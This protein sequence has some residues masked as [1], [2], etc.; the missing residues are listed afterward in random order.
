MSHRSHCGLVQRI[1]GF[2]ARRS[3]FHSLIVLLSAAL[4]LVAYPLRGDV[5][6]AETLKAELVA[7]PENGYA[8]L[9]IT[10]PGRSLLP[11]YDA[12]ITNNVLKIS[13]QDPISVKVDN[14]PLKLPTYVSIARQDPDGSAIRLALT[15]EYR[16]N[17]MEAG[18]KLFID[19]LPA[20]WSG[21]TPP[22]P[23][24][25]VKEL[26]LRAEE[27]LKKARA[28]ELA[29]LRGQVEPEVSLR[30]G[31]HP[32]FTRLAFLWNLP[33]D[34]AFVREGDIVK[35]TFNYD[36]DLDLSQLRAHL[37][38][39]I[40]DA[41]SFVDEGKLKFLLRLAKGVDIRAFR[42]EST[43]V[44]DVT[45]EGQALDPINETVQ[46]IL[47]PD[48]P[49]GAREIISA[50]GTP[51]VA[52]SEPK[53]PA[54][55]GHPAPVAQDKVVTPIIK[56]SAAEDKARAP[57][58]NASRSPSAGQPA[59]EGH[60]LPPAI[61][62]GAVEPKALTPLVGRTPPSSPE[63]TPAGFDDVARRF[64]AAEARRIGN[65]VRVVF[66]FPEPV[67]SAVFRRNHSIWLIFDTADP[68]DIRGMRSVLAKD[69]EDVEVVAH[70]DWQSI[71]VDLTDNA[72][73]TVGNDGNSWVMTIGESILE[74]SRPLLLERNV[75]SDGGTILHVPLQEPQYMRQLKDPFVGDAIT[76]V[77][78]FG[79][80]RG[81]LKPQSFAELE[82]LMSAHGLAVLSRIDDLQVEL[83][84]DAVLLQGPRGLFLSNDT[85]KH[86]SRIL[87]TIVDPAQPGQV[88][89]GSL[90]TSNTPDFLNKAKDFQLKIAAT[91]EGQRRIPRMDLA[92]FYLAHGLAQE[93]LGLMQLAAEDDP[94]IE[95]DTSFNLMTGAA[96]VLASRPKIALKHLNR[97]EL[98][99][100]P[101]AAVWQTIAAADLRDWPSA[102]ETIPRGRAV[103][104][105]YPLSVQNDFN[106]SGA[107]V[108]VEVND[109]GQAARILAEVDPSVLTADQAARYDLLRGRIA[110]ASGRSR[111]ALT[112]FELVRRSQDGPRAAEA[113]Y[114][115]LR[116]RYR[117]GDIEVDKAINELS[118]LAASWRGDET[119]LRTLRFL[120]QLYVQ[121]GEYR[122]AFEAMKAAVVANPDSETTRL[123][124]EEMNAV[125][126][127]L[128]L[129]G[130]AD[131]LKP[132]QALAL[133]YDFREL[134]PVGR[135]GD[136][137]VRS[138]ANRLVAV[139]LLDQAAELL[140]HQVDNRLKG[141]ARAQIAADL[142]VVYLMD[143][144]PDEALR[145]LNRTRQAQLP[146][147]LSRQRNIVEARAL[148]E[149]GRPDLALELVRNMNGEDVERLRADTLWAAGN[150]QA[151][152]EQL[153]Q[154][155]GGRWGDGVPLSDRER[156]DILKAAIGYS[157]AGDQFSL[158]RLR[159]KF[160]PK[161]A[162]SPDSKAFEVVSRSIDERGV[163]FTS[164]LNSLGR[165]DSLDIF[166]AEYQ[167][168]YLRPTNQSPLASGTEQG[169]DAEES[170]PSAA[171]VAVPLAPK[172]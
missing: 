51:P 8:R 69:A 84:G 93:A 131:D 20:S 25:V 144:K 120:S 14:V 48:L 24:S 11:H 125:F 113:A 71:R 128:F 70:D 95:R 49:E 115:A 169:A 7:T 127:S 31:L 172:G 28:L 88:D 146:R 117:D 5:A 151:A 149:S 91:P 116:V 43:Y 154:M 153:E 78:A 42:E 41:T 40:A 129:G 53:S 164:V 123:L 145:V 147:S 46:Q 39:G 32:T 1:L 74:P 61:D 136:E 75:R 54:S 82:A 73:A 138:L 107:Q 85:L 63:S 106:L 79:P 109:F 90:M 60:D 155:A 66:P 86:G 59:A 103:I 158:D 156:A 168:N 99:N 92:R 161:M 44:V 148:T 15:Q 132:V 47:T 142:G 9:V 56:A 45:P 4:T 35:L 143:R 12:L 165:V 30:I 112:S 98:R 87:D 18:E 89:L 152:G 171:S 94:A 67:S 101:D 100:S 17:T 52:A 134:T 76:V 23:D 170:L 130:K 36:A 80:A 3:A 96:Q 16:I 157:L 57:A 163:E 38:P 33:F 22:L 119:E 102:R 122:R 114:R 111:E 140:K 166:L 37:P 167:R 72:L 141:A 150:W 64:V 27:A 62:L 159:T 26:A 21:P 50:P 108:M 118:G 6:R 29:R 58:D 81:L 83:Q 133:F 110:D 104:G 77:T 121:K 126:A 2:R 13:F 162:D 68:I 124:Q 105:N 97:H 10:F 135:Q 65:T 139:D 160:T 34:T 19:L 55:D 137:M